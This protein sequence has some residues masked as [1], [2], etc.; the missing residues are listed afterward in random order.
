MG[1]GTEL[2]CQKKV[3]P[4][5]YDSR[6]IAVKRVHDLHVENARVRH[7]DLTHDLMKGGCRWLDKKKAGREWFRV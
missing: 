7:G 5:R 6:A 2:P 3:G 1:Y 4:M